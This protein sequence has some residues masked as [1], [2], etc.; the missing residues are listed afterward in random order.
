MQFHDAK[1]NQLHKR[2]KKTIME[3]YDLFPR[4]VANIIFTYCPAAALALKQ[5]KDRNLVARLLVGSKLSIQHF[6]RVDLILEHV[7]RWWWWRWFNCD[8]SSN[9]EEWIE[10]LKGTYS[11]SA[12]K[13]L[14]DRVD[15]L[16]FIRALKQQQTRDPYITTTIDLSLFQRGNGVEFDTATMEKIINVLL[17]ESFMLCLFLG[18]FVNEDDPMHI[19][20]RD[21]IQPNTLDKECTTLEYVGIF[22]MQKWS[23]RDS[24]DKILL[25]SHPLLLQFLSSVGITC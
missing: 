7:D 10:T 8:G 14:G 17:N 4:D 2:E 5:Q 22:C 6:K 1:K 9:E 25:H 16:Y 11:L 15:K 12:Y 23:C 24:H 19:Y 20:M 21:Y 18:R 3:L 13:A